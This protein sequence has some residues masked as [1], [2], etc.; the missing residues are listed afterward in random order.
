MLLGCVPPFSTVRVMAGVML[1]T[2][3]ST[4]SK[5]QLFVQLELKQ[6]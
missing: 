4:H 3:S 6:N 1:G 2:G 5:M